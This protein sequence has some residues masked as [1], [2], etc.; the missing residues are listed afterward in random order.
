ML[1]STVTILSARCLLANVTFSGPNH[2]PTLV[3]AS[4]PVPIQ[5]VQHVA[6]PALHEPACQGVPG[7]MELMQ[8]DW[9][10]GGGG[11]PVAVMSTWGQDSDGVGPGQAGVAIRAHGHTTLARVTLPFTH[12]TSPWVDLAT[13][14]QGG[15]GYGA[16]DMGDHLLALGADGT[17]VL[18]DQ[19]GTKIGEKNL[20]TTAQG[21]WPFAAGTHTMAVGDLVPNSGSYEQEIV[22]ATKTGLMWL[23]VNDLLA[24]GTVLPAAGTPQGAYV[25]GY[26]LETVRNYTGTPP[27]TTSHVQARTNQCLSATWAIARRPDPSAP[28][29]FDNK[30]HVLDQRG[31]YWRVGHGGQVDLWEN[32]EDAAGSRGWGYVGPVTGLGAGFL[33]VTAANYAFVTSTSTGT[34]IEATPWISL[35]GGDAIFQFAPNPVLIPRGWLRVRIPRSVVDGFLVFDWGGSM[36]ATGSG[37]RQAWMWSA[38]PVGLAWNN[39]VEGYSIDSSDVVAG[40]WSSVVEPLSIDPTTGLGTGCNHLRLRSFFGIIPALT[41]QA[42]HAA[43]LPASSETALVFG[44]GGGRVRTK[45]ILTTLTSPTDLRLGNSVPQQIGSLPTSSVDLGFGGG[46]LAVRHEPGNLLRIWFGTVAHP[47][48]RPQNYA[49]IG[50]AL[51][52]HEVVSGAV[53]MMTWAPGSG[54]PLVQQTVTYHPLANSRGAYGV[55][56]LKVGVLLPNAGD[57]LVVATMSGDLIVYNID[58]ATHLLSE[59]WRTY[60]AGSAGFYNSI[61]IEDLD[62]DGKKEL[63]VAGSL[64]LWRLTQ[65]GE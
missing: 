50:G 6:N 49:Q 60:V 63:Y 47:C 25:S 13:C 22:V 39:L 64:G 19:V 15:P 9:S 56:G 51:D 42:V 30:L 16:P 20:T 26:Y 57:E 8:L 14:S 65:P 23:H 44:C 27:L 46:A 12:P 36:A 10:S 21:H 29:G 33:P 4:N 2:V 5:F 35:H 37:A 52:H 45:L 18:I 55:V 7:D 43:Y 41:Q 32:E 53:H 58:P 62:D 11:T 61:A 24:P 54:P 38:S 40:T 59:I 34:R 17:L 31:N 48:V 1:G 3:A 28:S